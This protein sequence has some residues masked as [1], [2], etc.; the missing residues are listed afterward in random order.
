MIDGERF[1]D[2]DGFCREFS[3]F[4]DAYVWQG[5][6]DAF[7]DILRGGFGTPEGGFVLR[8]EHSEESRIALGYETTALRLES[9]LRTCHP[10]NREQ[11]AS[12]LSRRGS[13]SVPP[14]STNWWRSSVSTAQAEMRQRMASNS[15]SPD[16]AGGSDWSRVRSGPPHP[17]AP[18]VGDSPADSCWD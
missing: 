10:T 8:W 5:S 7:N 6:L 4:L 3:S 14:C 16:R 11:I 17:I 1:S 13:E 2:F 9:L 15:S 18:G 12:R